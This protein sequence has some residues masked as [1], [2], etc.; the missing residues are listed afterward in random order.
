MKPVFLS[1]GD[2]KVEMMIVE[3]TE[4]ERRAGNLYD[5]L[6]DLGHTF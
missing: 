5:S 1:F 4:R 6:E 2:A 3:R